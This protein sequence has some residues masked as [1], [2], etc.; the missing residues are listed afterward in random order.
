MNIDYKAIASQ[1]GLHFDNFT[2]MLYY[3]QSRVAYLATHNKNLTNK[4]Y[5]AICDIENIL[6]NITED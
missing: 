6:N 5:H 3:L 1:T 2:D 4:Q